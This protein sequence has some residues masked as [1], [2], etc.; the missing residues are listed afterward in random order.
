[1]TSVFIRPISPRSITL[2]RDPADAARELLCRVARPTQERCALPGTCGYPL[3]APGE[4][5]NLWAARQA[6]AIRSVCPRRCARFVKSSCPRFRL[7]PRL[8]LLLIT[9]LNP[10]RNVPVHALNDRSQSPHRALLRVRSGAVIKTIMF[11]AA[12]LRLV[13]GLRQYASQRELPPNLQQQP[14]G[15]V[16]LAHNLDP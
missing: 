1:M 2:Y 15:V 8:A 11:P 14:V 13:R 7:V 10:Y 4:K 12:G 3:S 6:F 16:W 9:T 5:K